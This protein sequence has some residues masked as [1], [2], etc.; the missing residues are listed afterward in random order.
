ML[1]DTENEI[2]ALTRAVEEVRVVFDLASRER[3]LAE[4]VRQSEANGLWDNVEQAQ[5]LMQ[6]ISALRESLEPW[7]QLSRQVADVEALAELIAE[8]GDEQPD[9]EAELDQELSQARREF[10]KLELATVLHDK[11]DTAPAILTITAGAG[12]T[13]ACDWAEMLLRMY[14]MWA[15]DQGYDF[16]LI[17]T[18]PGEQAGLR[19]VTL[20]VTGRYA[21]G[22]LK[23]EAGVHRLVRL[24]PFDSSKRRHTSFASVDVMPEVPEA[25]QV[26][27]PAEDLRVETFRSSGAGGQHVNKTDSA[28]RI[29]HLPTGISVQSQGDRSQHANRRAA[30]QVL[31]ARLAQRERDRQKAELEGLRGEKGDIAFANQIRSYVMQPYTMVKDLRTGSETS[32]VQGVLNGQISDFIRAYLLHSAGKAVTENAQ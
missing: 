32:D 11:Y 18:V 1:R 22:Y 17:S 3:E 21:Y 5:E 15:Q 4:L 6:R 9:L 30:M 14:Q 26:A 31:Q 29:T 2:Q 7:E 8:A 19:N 20:R 25:E 13:E 28:V 27:I 23:A 12:G 16:E 10:E 24:S